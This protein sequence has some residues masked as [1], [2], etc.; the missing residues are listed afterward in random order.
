[1]LSKAPSKVHIGEKV[2]SSLAKQP[3]LSIK[4]LATRLRV[5]RQF[6]A[7]FLAAL[8]ERGELASRAVGPARIY[9][10]T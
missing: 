10:K 1:M 6:M 3:G 4:E 7:G 2:K 5:N 9:F 8:E